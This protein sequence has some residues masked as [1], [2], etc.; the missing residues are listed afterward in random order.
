MKTE[1]ENF[2]SKHASG[3]KETITIWVALSGG[4]DSVVLLDLVHS[5]ISSTSLRS[6]PRFRLKAI[7]VNHGLSPN[8]DKWQSFC[9]QLCSGI[10]VELCTREVSIDRT[11]NIES[12]ARRQRYQVFK[13]VCGV[14]SVLLTAHH[15][16]DQAETLLFRFLRGGHP[17]SLTGIP[18]LRHWE[19]LQIFRPLLKQ[20]RNNILEY[21]K[22]K[23]L[24][25][26]E[27]ESNQDL[28]FSR[29]F[30]RHSIIPQLERQWPELVLSLS[31][32]AEK[33]DSYMQLLGSLAAADYERCLGEDAVLNTWG[34]NFSLVRFLELSEV[35]QNNLVHYCLAQSAFPFPSQKSVEY[36]LESC[37]QLNSESSSNNFEIIWKSGSRLF[38]WHSFEKHLF[39]DC[40]QA[41]TEHQQEELIDAHTSIC[42]QTNKWRYESQK[43][44]AECFSNFQGRSLAIR[45]RQGGERCLPAGRAHSQSLKKLLQEY[46][47]P[48]WERSSLPLFYCGDELIAVA[49]LWVCEGFLKPGQ[50]QPITRT[51]I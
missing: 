23:K 17:H 1:L 32:L 51:A 31:Q 16:N 42:L 50:E 26:V 15:A 37:Q 14:G 8:A 45:F 4:V 11:K 28:G 38:R 48:T 44:V 46:R 29:N 21:A 5:Y 7:H 25:W 3:Q 34:V 35:Q 19:G 12:E 40:V 9:E 24:N 36:L 18:M 27:D 13:E 47:V 41:Y 10:G 43:T 30:L 39:L 6:S 49:D 2:L 22:Q 33:F 20:P